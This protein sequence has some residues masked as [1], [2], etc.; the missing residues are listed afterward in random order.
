MVNIVQQMSN[1]L[2][3][4]FGLMFLFSEEIGVF[5]VAF[6]LLFKFL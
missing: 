4:F 2:H 6:I 5:G 3:L 1:I